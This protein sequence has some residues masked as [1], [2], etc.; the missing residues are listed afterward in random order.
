MIISIIQG[1]TALQYLQKSASMQRIILLAVRAQTACLYYIACLDK[2]TYEYFWVAE[3]YN[4]SYLFLAGEY[5]EKHSLLNQ[6]ICQVW[7]EFAVCSDWS[8]WDSMEKT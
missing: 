5:V 2:Y 3:S 4:S 6:R 1:R 7:W 8:C